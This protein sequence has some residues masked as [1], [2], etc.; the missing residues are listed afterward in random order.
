ML[1]A[2]LERWMPI[3]L[4]SRGVST[5]AAP[6]VHLTIKESTLIEIFQGLGPIIFT[7]TNKTKVPIVE[8]LDWL[9]NHVRDSIFNDKTGVGNRKF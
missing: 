1:G 3:L 5:G 2:A 4:L 6:D 8:F 9:S 7:R